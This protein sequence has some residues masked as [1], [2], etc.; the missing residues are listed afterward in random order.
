MSRKVRMASYL[1]CSIICILLLRVIW[2]MA[3][4]FS[5]SEINE[6]GNRGFC[7]NTHWAGLAPALR[8]RVF[9]AWVAIVAT[10]SMDSAPSMPCWCI[11]R[12]IISR[13]M[14]P[15]LSPLPSWK[16]AS[17][18]TNRTWIPLWAISSSN[19]K[20]FI[21]PSAS[22]SRASGSPKYL[23]HPRHRALLI[24]W[25]SRLGRRVRIWYVVASSTWFKKVKV[26][27]VISLTNIK[28]SITRSLNLRVIGTDFDGLCCRGGRS[29]SHTAHFKARAPIKAIGVALACASWRT[30][31]LLWGWPKFVWTLFSTDL[32]HRGSWSSLM[33]GKVMSFAPGSQSAMDCSGSTSTG[34]GVAAARRWAEVST[35][36][37]LPYKKIATR[38]V[39]SNL[40]AGLVTS[41]RSWDSIEMVSSWCNKTA[42]RC[43]MSG[44]SIILLAGK[45]LTFG[46]L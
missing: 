31:V 7:P 11:K 19:S 28:S 1:T 40:D 45:R 14:S 13:A 24:C 12:C 16:W 46:V 39:R 42:A 15:C 9:L 2:C 35:S 32:I 18:G 38:T 3:S 25:A 5:V 36:I 33:P 27:P 8:V 10:I 37:G 4:A 29:L 6:A 34:R 17:G 26:S 21:A 22:S 41:D 44:I 23:N 43:V 30:K 20:L